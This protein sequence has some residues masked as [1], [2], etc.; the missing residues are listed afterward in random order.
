MSASATDDDF[1]NRSIRVKFE[2]VRISPRITKLFEIGSLREHGGLKLVEVANIGS[3]RRVDFL[4][5]SINFVPDRF[6]VWPAQRKRLDV[7]GSA[8]LFVRTSRRNRDCAVTII[9]PKAVVILCAPGIH[10]V[11]WLDPR[12]AQHKFQFVEICSELPVGS[13]IVQ[14][15]LACRFESVF[16]IVPEQRL[17][18]GAVLVS[19]NF[20]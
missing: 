10:D 11:L 9:Q 15:S 1:I 19:F 14:Q 3:A 13:T 18:F 8:E 5:S 12:F 17:G 2:P 6:E 4:Y 7:I 16:H 20:W